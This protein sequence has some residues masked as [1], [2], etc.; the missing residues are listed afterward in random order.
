MSFAVWRAR[1]KGYH[2]NG[3]KDA[4]VDRD[5]HAGGELFSVFESVRMREAPKFVERIPTRQI[6][7]VYSLV[8]TLSKPGTEHRKRNKRSEK[9]SSSL[10]H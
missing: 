2:G 1:G 8:T 4:H 7:E 9:L 5:S 6:K 3:V 10:L